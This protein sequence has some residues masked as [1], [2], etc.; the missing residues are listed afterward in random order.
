MLALHHALLPRAGEVRFGTGVSTSRYLFNL[1]CL[2]VTLP[3]LLGVLALFGTAIGIPAVLHLVLIAVLLPFVWKW[4]RRNRPG[5]YDPRAIPAMLLPA[6][7]A[8][9]ARVVG[10]R[11]AARRRHPPTRAG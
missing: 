11:E 9:P 2:L 4:M 6:A 10:R 7:V 3:L 8:A 1:G 5:T